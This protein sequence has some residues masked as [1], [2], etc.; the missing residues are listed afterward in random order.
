L[1][2][3]ALLTFRQPLPEA[4]CQLVRPR[5]TVRERG[6]SIYE[7]ESVHWEKVFD[8][9][10]THGAALSGLPAFGE[11]ASFNWRSPDPA[12]VGAVLA[13]DHVQSACNPPEDYDPALAPPHQGRVRRGRPIHVRERPRGR[14]ARVGEDQV[15][16]TELINALGGASSGECGE[17]VQLRR[18]AVSGWARF[19][20]TRRC[21]VL[22]PACSYPPQPCAVCGGPLTPALGLWI[23][24]DRAAFSEALGAEELGHG[25]A[26][27]QHPL[28]VSLEQAARLRRVFRGKG[29]CLDP[30]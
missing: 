14:L 7:L 5:A 9:L 27:L 17:A 30:V 4:V 8:T 13:S 16:S 15:F 20:P 12:W 28:I 24:R 11:R 26:G 6:I 29:F 2:I 22:D 18:E 23:A 3:Y 25:H 1:G 19:Y 21:R 10:E